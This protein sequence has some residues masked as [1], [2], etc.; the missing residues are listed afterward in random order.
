MDAHSSENG[1]SATVPV[2]A[3]RAYGS[4]TMP[5]AASVKTLSLFNE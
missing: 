2:S 4:S 5:S 1:G 3:C